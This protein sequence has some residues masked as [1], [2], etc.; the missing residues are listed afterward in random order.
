MNIFLS[1]SVRDVKMIEEISKEFNDKDLDLYIAEQDIQPGS[2][3]LDKIRDAIKKCDIFVVV[4]SKNGLRSKWVHSEIGIAIA[5]NKRIVPIVE[6]GVDVP[7]QLSGTEFIRFD[8][9]EPES[10]LDSLKI[11]LSK[12]KASRESIQL[13]DTIF[14]FVVVLLG[15][16]LIPALFSKK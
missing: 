5:S 6:E 4:I 10:A 8:P 3:L 16:I 12:L 11:F 2:N 13:S 7:P 9:N 15:I 14:V 1:H